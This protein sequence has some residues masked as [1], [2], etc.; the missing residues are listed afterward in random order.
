MARKKAAPKPKVEETEEETTEATPGTRSQMEKHEA[1]V[2]WYESEYEEDLSE[3][4]PAE[5]IARF[6]AKRNEFRQ[7]DGYLKQ[8][9]KEAREKAAAKET[10]KAPAKGKAKGKSTKGKKADAEEVF[11]D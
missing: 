8:W 6:A 10:K 5:V 4:E 11:E 2:S 3:L 9:G 1:F 7:S